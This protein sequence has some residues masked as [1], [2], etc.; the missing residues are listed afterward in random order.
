MVLPGLVD[1]THSNVQAARS[2]L[3]QGLL[4]ISALSDSEHPNPKT[5]HYPS[6]QSSA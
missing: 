6:L 4:E 3:S 1:P 2:L 5:G